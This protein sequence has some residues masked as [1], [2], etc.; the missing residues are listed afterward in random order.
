MT[1]QDIAENFN[2]Q[3]QINQDLQGQINLSDWFIRG[4]VLYAMADTISKFL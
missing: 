1:N 2:A 3:V 4:L